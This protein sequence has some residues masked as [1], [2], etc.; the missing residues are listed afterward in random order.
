MGGD[1]RANMSRRRTKS[2]PNQLLR[3]AR[4]SKG[5]SGDDLAR[6][7]RD[8]A[9]KRGEPAPGADATT[10]YRWE[11]GEQTPSHYYVR[12]LTMLFDRSPQELGLVGDFDQGLD[13]TAEALELARQAEASD[14]GPAILESLDRTVLR[15]RRDYSRTPPE[16]LAP[17][18]QRHLRTVRQLLSRRLRFDQHRELLR[19]A[20]WLALLLATVYF[21]LK[22]RESAEAYRDVALR[23]GTATGDAELEAWSWETPAWFTLA[24]GR[25]RDAIDYAR[26]GQAVAPPTSVKVA[27]YLQEARAWAR[28]RDASQT[29]AAMR[30]AWEALERLPPPRYPDDHFT[31]DP[32]KFS[33]YAATAYVWLGDSKLAEEH[34]RRVIAASG[35]PLSPNYWPTRVATTQIDLGLALAQQGQIDEAAYEGSKAFDSPFLRRSTLWRARE[36]DVALSRHIGVHEVHDFHE[37]YLLSVHDSASH[38]LD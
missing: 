5:W 34:A 4:E 31:F 3:L 11:R 30:E 33:F 37:R 38:D 2:R 7:S 28:L 22:Q 17:I 25:F 12:L 21:D 32:A 9:E 18:A 26:A 36:L 20:G 27:V 8:L 10:I 16:L 23:L 13:G 35:N 15:L 29:K 14:V 1:Y 6:E 19:A 24:G